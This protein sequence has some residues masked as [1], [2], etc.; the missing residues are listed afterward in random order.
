MNSSDPRL[1]WATIWAHPGLLAALT[2]FMA[3]VATRTFRA[4][5][6]SA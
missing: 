6:R 4:Y 3:W 1:D 5:Q 2:A